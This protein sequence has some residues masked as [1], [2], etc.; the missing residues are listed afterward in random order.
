MQPNF[1]SHEQGNSTLLC[2][3]KHFKYFI[4]VYIRFI[5]LIFKEKKKLMTKRYN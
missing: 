3:N 1:K 2:V 4:I 5:I